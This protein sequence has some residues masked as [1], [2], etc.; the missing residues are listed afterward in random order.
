MTLSLAA[1]LL[2]GL[3]VGPRTQAQA[4]TYAGWY[5]CFYRSPT[6]LSEH[7]DPLELVLTGVHV[8]PSLSAVPSPFVSSGGMV[9]LQCASWEK[10]DMFVLMKEGEPRPS[11]T[12][13][14][15]RHSRGHFQALFP[16][17]PVTPRL[18]W[19]FRCYG[20]YR[21]APQVWSQPSDPLELLVSGPS[22]DPSL[23]L[24]GPSP[25]AALATGEG[26]THGDN[27][28]GHPSPGLEKYQKILI[29][30]SVASVLLLALL[31]LLLQLQHQKK[32]CNSGALHPEAENRAL[33]KSSGSG[34]VA[35]AREET[36]YAEV[37]EFQPE[38][39][40]QKDR[41]AVASEDPQD[42]TYAQL[43]SL[44]LEQE[45]SA[46]PSSQA[47]EPPAEPS[48]YAALAVH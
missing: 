34:S 11:S 12:L 37:R 32:C 28:T 15:Q 24:T 22:V 38:E 35:P 25:T 40:T 46:H 39:D 10:F 18:R 8:K 41:Q 45:T 3:S 42:V 13:D 31:L 21:H 4:D 30:V 36:Q 7:S 47:G 19:T 2:L 5:R 33:R 48:M 17:D 23:P 6:G 29:R 1:L 26:R 16:V 44:N 14:S 20:Y 9:T 43:K 27:A